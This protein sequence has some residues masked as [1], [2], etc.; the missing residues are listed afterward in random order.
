[1]ESWMIVGQLQELIQNVKKAKDEYEG[2]ARNWAIVI[3]SLE[4]VLAYVKY[5]CVE[6]E[7]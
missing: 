6:E 3:T 5:Y 4:K 1:M 7:E 2:K